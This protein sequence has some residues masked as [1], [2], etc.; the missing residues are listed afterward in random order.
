ME[1]GCGSSLCYWLKH[2]PGI[3]P[4]GAEHE[5]FLWFSG[6]NW[7]TVLLGR[8]KWPPFVLIVIWVFVMS[9]PND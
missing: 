1:A 3:W 8:G 4:M 6:F 9:E 5:G 2:G 7:V